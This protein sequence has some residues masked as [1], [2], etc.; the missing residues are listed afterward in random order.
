[1]WVAL[2][3]KDYQGDGR[4]FCTIQPRKYPR[5]DTLNREYIARNKAISTDRKVT[6]ATFKWNEYR[7]DTL[8]T[9]TNYHVDLMPLR[10]RNNEHYDM[11]LSKYQAVGSV[12]GH[13]GLGP[14]VTIASTT[15]S[16][17]PGAI[18]HSSDCILAR[19]PV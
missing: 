4:F 3:D 15:S 14:N 17:A 2:V 11:V 19:N 1:M 9:L 12:F 6:Y 5:G 13:N 18:Q 10:A 8:A 7:F 16:S